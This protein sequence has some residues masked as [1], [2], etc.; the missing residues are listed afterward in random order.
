MTDRIRLL[1]ETLNLTASQFADEIDVQRSGVSHIMSGRNKASLEFIRKILAR[2]PEISPDWLISGKGPMYRHT[3][4]KPE[5]AET[6]N[7]PHIEKNSTKELFDFN[8]E[9]SEE[10][11]GK[12]AHGD[13]QDKRKVLEKS[14]KET[15][16][17][18]N[19]AAQIERIIILYNDGSFKDYFPGE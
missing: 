18:Q 10:I 9:A 12:S 14:T 5:N 16:N 17:A 7:Q 19:K 8:A 3:S 15:S 4:Q 11:P 13:Y 2:Y 6:V 1:L